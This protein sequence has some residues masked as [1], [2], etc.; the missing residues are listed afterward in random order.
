MDKPT[1]GQVFR[2]MDSWRRLKHS[3]DEPWDKD[4]KVEMGKPGDPGTVIL[5]W[6]EPRFALTGEQFDK[7]RAELEMRMRLIEAGVAEPDMITWF[8]CEVIAATTGAG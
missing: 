3:G 7:L 1:V 5:W 4:G 6:T 8:A 2:L